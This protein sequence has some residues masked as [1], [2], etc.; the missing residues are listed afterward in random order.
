MKQERYTHN[1]IYY[2]KKVYAVGG[3]TYGDDEQA[4]LDTCECYDFDKNKWEW[5]APMQS[6]RCTAF[7]FIYTNMIYVFGGYTGHLARKTAIERYNKE[8]NRW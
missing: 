7:M 5:I 4:I 3:R 6:K 2:N 8:T 1:T